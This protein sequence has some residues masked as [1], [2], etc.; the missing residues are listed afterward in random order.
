MVL[1]F[2]RNYFNILYT[3]KMHSLSVYSPSKAYEVQFAQL[4]ST[5][6]TSKVMDN[7]AN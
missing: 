5:D 7:I 4:K 6:F 1:W 3:T 2:H